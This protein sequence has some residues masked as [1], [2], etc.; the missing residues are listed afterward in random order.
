[1]VKKPKIQIISSVK[2]CEICGK[3]PTH[4]LVDGIRT[5]TACFQKQEGS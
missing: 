4:R 1:M 2:N 3:V 5:C